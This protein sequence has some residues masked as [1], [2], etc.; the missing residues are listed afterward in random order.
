MRKPA[1]GAKG[2]PTHEITANHD[3]LAVPTVEQRT[4][5]QAEQQVGQ[6]ARRGQQSG[7]RGRMREREYQQGQGQGRNVR[8]QC[9]NGLTIPKQKEVT[10][11]P[12]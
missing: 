5:W 1:E 11:A 10:I 12:K 9:R 4:R 2:K 8:P 7:L 6:E 3:R